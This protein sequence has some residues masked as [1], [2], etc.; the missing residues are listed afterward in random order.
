MEKELNIELNIIFWC[1][2]G[3]L[4]K[5]LDISDIETWYYISIPAYIYIVLLIVKE[6]QYRAKY[7]PVKVYN[8]RAKHRPIKVCEYIYLYYFRYKYKFYQ[9]R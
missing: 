5:E 8:Y 9:K 1:F 4:N 6:C 3:K 2:V 7:R